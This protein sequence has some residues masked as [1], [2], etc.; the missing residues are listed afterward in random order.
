MTP[1][2]RRLAFSLT[3]MLPALAAAADL[4]PDAVFL[5]AGIAENTRAASGG[6]SW[7][8]GEHETLSLPLGLR[9]EVSLGRW[10]TRSDAGTSAAW[11]TDFG[12]TPVVRYRF[13]RSRLF[14]EAGIGVHF[15]SPL[16]VNGDRHFSTRWNFGDHLAI[17]GR[18]GERDRHELAL[19]LQH[20]SNGGVRKP[21]PGEDFLHLR[22]TY[23]LLE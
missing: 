15:V 18:F 4:S 3:L 1:R 17:G 14:V 23:H 22:Y 21:N 13:Q 16:Y 8:W 20:Y 10:R 2:L 7:D 11:F 5:Q 12:L 19:R 9:G 6:L